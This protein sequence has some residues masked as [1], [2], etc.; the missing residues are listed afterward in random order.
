[1][2]GQYSDDVDDTSVEDGEI[3]I[4]LEPMPLE[5]AEL[6]AALVRFVSTEI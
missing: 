3:E 5:I 1:M 6:C 4:E 2:G